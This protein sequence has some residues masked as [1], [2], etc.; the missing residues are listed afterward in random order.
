MSGPGLVKK[1]LFPAYADAGANVTF[2]AN[3]SD[4]DADEME[5]GSAD[6]DETALASSIDDL[7]S[8]ATTA[9]QDNRSYTRE[10]PITG[11]GTDRDSLPRSQPI[12]ESSSTYPAIAE[13]KTGRQ[14]AVSQFFPSTAPSAV[15]PLATTRSTSTTTRSGSIDQA[16]PATSPHRS[17]SNGQS[18]AG[19]GSQ[20][21]ALHT[22]NSL[23]KSLE[24]SLETNPLTDEALS[25][26]NN[27]TNEYTR[28]KYFQGDDTEDAISDILSTASEFGTV[29]NISTR[30]AEVNAMALM[31]PVAIAEEESDTEQDDGDG[32]IVPNLSLPMLDETPE[33]DQTVDADDRGQNVSSSTSGMVSAAFRRMGNGVGTF[34]RSGAVSA[35]STPRGQ[36]RVEDYLKQ[37]RPNE[38]STTP[39]SLLLRS[40]GS[41]AYQRAATRQ[42][43]LLSP[44]FAHPH[45]PSTKTSSSD[46][47]FRRQ[48]SSLASP[49]RF[50]RGCFSFDNTMSD[51]GGPAQS[52]NQPSIQESRSLSPFDTQLEPRSSQVRSLLQSKSW[53]AG[54]AKLSFRSSSNDNVEYASAFRAIPGDIRVLHGKPNH[55]LTLEPV[56][57]TQ[58]FSPSRSTAANAIA[59][60]TPHR[61]EIEREDALD[62]LACLVERSIAFEKETTTEKMENEEEQDT[63]TCNES[64][65]TPSVTDDNATVD[66]IVDDDRVSTFVE[67][68]TR[69]ETRIRS[70]PK[71][72]RKARVSS[73]I[74][75]SGVLSSEVIDAINELRGI[76]RVHDDESEHETRME[77]LDELLRSHV[78]AGE[79]KRAARSASTWLRSIGRADDDASD[80]ISVRTPGQ[81]YIES[82][83]SSGTNEAQRLVDNRTWK[84]AAIGESD[85]DTGSFEEKMDALS[86]R[87][88][89]HS[90]ELQLKEKAEEA[91][92]L[93]AELSECR[94]EIGRQKSASQ[95]DV[96]FRSQNR[97][98]LD[99]DDDSDSDVSDVGANI[100]GDEDDTALSASTEKQTIGIE[101]P[102]AQNDVSLD[103]VKTETNLLKAALIEANNT[104]RKMHATEHGNGATEKAPVVPIP[105]RA[106]NGEQRDMNDTGAQNFVTTWQKVTNLPPPPD[107]DLYSPI[108][109]ALLKEWT[110]DSAMHRSLLS[111]IERVLQ[112]AD[113][114]TIPPLTISSLD[115]Q[116]RDGFQMHILPLLLK[117]SD[118][119]VDVMTRAQRR[120]TFDIA[121]TVHPNVDEQS[122]HTPRATN[123]LMFPYKASHGGSLMDSS[124]LV[125]EAFLPGTEAGSGNRG[126][127]RDDS[128]IGTSSVSQSAI[129]AHISNSSSSRFRPVE[130]NLMSSSLDGPKAVPQPEP[131]DVS[132]LMTGASPQRSGQ[133]GLMS[134]INNTFGGLLSRGRKLPQ[135]TEDDV[136]EGQEEHGPPLNSWTPP[137]FSSEEGETDEP[138]PYQR[139]LSCPPGRIGVTFVQYRGHAMVS[140]VS[141]ESPLS[142]WVFP[143]DI[144][145]AIDEVPVSGMRV[146]DIVTLLTARKDRQRALRVISSHAMNE[147]TLNTSVISEPGM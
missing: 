77:I 28:V 114:N 38:Q 29:I 89:L 2:A 62:I 109:N 56:V 116:V 4:N 133:H 134:A 58:N 23:E 10:D 120:T 126:I 42:P 72:R 52:L 96:S 83:G 102:H 103:D 51:A 141:P 30:V 21:S 131:R 66:A 7:Q 101:A 147:F 16:F 123:T 11:T 104:I 113:P 115:H 12:T 99:R 119:L 33:T 121:I 5:S 54:S 8:E 95:A 127:A 88:M 139:V 59:L 17:G 50:A 98:I 9:I 53:D 97:S 105:Q 15:R 128:E 63:E 143:S 64:S 106:A 75:G 71:N 93:N 32:E 122:S 73:D 76:S 22:G 61:V 78:Y 87:A 25:S 125:D 65:P 3:D 6:C 117:R 130:A 26:L 82:A 92:R 34:G 74:L 37:Y 68:G 112:G 90:V 27:N 110:I 57:P 67:N 85:T 118:I 108:V 60:R 100:M 13:S 84:L 80:V 138:Q 132:E 24:N 14:T 47:S 1:L 44:R 49:L 19:T 70:P 31:T 144:L 46:N 48:A 39:A 91:K 79:M 43:K 137:T 135:S 40:P 111:W 136:S 35:P 145:I 81:D 20:S 69:S 36:P 142:G 86:I 18:H 140:D 146:R 45:D 41:A 55:Y 129:T 107:H 124:L 94:A